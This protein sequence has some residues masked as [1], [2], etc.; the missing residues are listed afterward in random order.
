M[1]PPVIETVFALKCSMVRVLTKGVNWGQ[2][3]ERGLT[4]F[5]GRSHY[6]GLHELNERCQHVWLVVGLGA[7]TCLDLFFF[8]NKHAELVDSWVE[9]RWPY[10]RVDQH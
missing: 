8:F 5:F 1:K 4:F 2:R 10:D 9:L 6:F 7:D 3:T